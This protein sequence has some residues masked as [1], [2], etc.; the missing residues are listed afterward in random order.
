MPRQQPIEDRELNAHGTLSN[1]ADYS[2]VHGYIDKPNF[3]KG[4][5]Y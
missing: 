3:W 5:D 1:Q 2:L 4:I